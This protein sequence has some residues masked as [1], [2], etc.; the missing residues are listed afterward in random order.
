ML[1]SDHFF[2]LYFFPAFILLYLVFSKRIAFGNLIIIIFSL[3]FYSSFGLKNLPILIFP[4]IADFLIALWIYKT[5]N[6]KQRLWILSTAVFFNLLLL[7]YYKYANFLSDNMLILF[8]NSEFLLSLQ[9]D[10]LL[11]VGISF[12]TFQR[13]SY[14]IDTYRKQIIPEK[15]LLKYAAYASLFPHLIAGPIVRYSQ[16]KNQLAKRVINSQ[17]IYLASQL[18][19]A[20]LFF[21]IIIANQLFLLEEHLTLFLMQLN[22]LESILLML[23]FSFRIYFDFMGYSLMALGL[24]KFAGF[25]FPINFDSPYQS[26]SITEFWRRWNITLGSWLRDYLYIPLGGSKKGESRTYV[27]LLITMLLAGLWHGANWNF[28]IWGSIHGIFLAIERFFTIHSDHRLAKLHRLPKIMKVAYCFL[29]VT[30]AWT[31]FKF[32]TPQEIF[33]LLGNVISFKFD[34]IDPITRNHIIAT[35]PAFLIAFIWSFLF[36]ERLIPLKHFNYKIGIFLSIAFILILGY[37]LIRR[38]IPFIYFQ[39]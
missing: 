20:G 38:S 35:F 28:V 12:I 22:S 15:N 26:N 37:S 27:N 21:K 1:I 23:C 7:G 14:L 36:K 19:V 34:E 2:L 30:L 13:I 11:P 29:L 3:L 31:T 9:K 8:P 25:D 39:F 6:H 4:L 33:Q 16:I 10:I 5:K 24:A 17:T 32:A 18:F